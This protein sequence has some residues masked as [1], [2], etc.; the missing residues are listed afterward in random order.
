MSNLCWEFVFKAATA[1]KDTLT[2]LGIIVGGWWTYTRFIRARV[3]ETALDIDLTYSTVD[4]K[5][6]NRLTF[7]NVVL[8]NLGK[9]KLRARERMNVAYDHRA[10]DGKEHVYK[11]G[12]GVKIRKIPTNLSSPSWLDWYGNSALESTLQ[13]IN[14]LKGYV[15]SEHQTDFWM[16]PGESYSLAAPIILEDGSYLAM[17]TFIGVSK[18]DDE[19]WQRMFLI[20]VP[21]TNS[22]TMQGTNSCVVA[23][24]LWRRT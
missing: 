24:H 17:V 19:F 8:K 22:A 18:K 12:L 7:L 23:T 6:G 5:T 15:K 9:V 1:L 4:Y 14:L 16:E 2:A 10:T 13:E 21:G 3:D 20:Q 11:F